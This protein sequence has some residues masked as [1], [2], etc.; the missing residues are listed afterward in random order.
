MNVIKETAGLKMLGICFICEA[1]INIEDDI[2]LTKDNTLY[3]VLSS[4]TKFLIY[5]F[6][7][8]VLHHDA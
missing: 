1:L 8:F 6:L 5:S 4:S 7:N 3:Q 2:L